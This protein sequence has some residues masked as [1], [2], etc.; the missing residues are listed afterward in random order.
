MSLLNY[1][2]TVPARQS[3]AEIAA[4]LTAA[5]VHVGAR[6]VSFRLPYL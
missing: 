4:M 3:R 1:T 6:E 2:T 5:G